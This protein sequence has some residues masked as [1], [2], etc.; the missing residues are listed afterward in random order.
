LHLDDEAAVK[1]AEKLKT[2][3]GMKK[4]SI[5][6]NHITFEGAQA[7][8]KSDEQERRAQRTVSLSL[9]LI[10]AS[11]AYLSIRDMCAWVLSLEMLLTGSALYIFM[12]AAVPPLPVSLFSCLDSAVRSNRR[13][14]GTSS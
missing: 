6:L 8:G 1:C 4:F 9:Y 7:L 2:S 5:S 14:S 10:A 13:G 3:F 12:L 11:L